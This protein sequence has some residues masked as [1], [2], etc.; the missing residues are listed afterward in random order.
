MLK[1]FLRPDTNLRRENTELRAENAR[2]LGAV[3]RRDRENK[4]LREENRRLRLQV[5]ALKRGR[6]RDAEGKFV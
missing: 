3:A 2:F 1:S 6:H 5:D 4:N